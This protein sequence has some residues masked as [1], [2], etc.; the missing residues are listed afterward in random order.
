M[1]GRVGR[2]SPI[3]CYFALGFVARVF[4]TAFGI[5]SAFGFAVGFG[6]AGFFGAAD[7]AA[8]AFGAT[9]F[10]AIAFKATGLAA[11]A[12]GAALGFD[13]ELVFAIGFH[14]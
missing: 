7:L 6:F 12:L 10:A 2:L 3:C 8:G 9:A 11:T 4:T 13:L 1:V 14:Q 5:G